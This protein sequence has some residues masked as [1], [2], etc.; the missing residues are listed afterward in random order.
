MKREREEMDLLP[1]APALGGLGLVDPDPAT[2]G[3]LTGMNITLHFIC[4][5]VALRMV[6]VPPEVLNKPKHPDDS[7]PEIR[8]LNA[9]DDDDLVTVADMLAKHKAAG[10]NET[11]GRLDLEFSPHDE[12]GETALLAA[13]NKKSAYNTAIARLLVGAGSN[14]NAAKRTGWTP[15]LVAADNGDIE[16]VK[17]LASLGADIT[18]AIRNSFSLLH[19][20]ARAKGDNVAYVKYLVEETPLRKFL[21]IM[22]EDTMTP[23]ANAAETGNLNICKYLRPLSAVSAFDR[24]DDGSSPPR[25]NED[26]DEDEEDEGQVDYVYGCDGY[27]RTPLHCAAERGHKMVVDYLLETTH[28]WGLVRGELEVLVIDDNYQTPLHF[29]VIGGHTSIVRDLIG[30]DSDPNR[31]D[32]MGKTPLHYAALHATKS[33]ELVT[34]LFSRIH[35]DEFG[36][37]WPIDA[38]V[39]T[40]FGEKTAADLASEWGNTRAAAIIAGYAQRR[41]RRS[42]WY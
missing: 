40:E 6:P 34:A 16:A 14:V 19:I 39:K 20:V 8:L 4:R 35:E 3:D 15:I 18:H 9:I 41:R 30:A 36:V 31:R 28:E 7:R 21:T 32:M 10:G 17:W 42:S 5:R 37:V 11:A 27:I 2:L 24:R 1:C 29:A 38:N 23:L 25:L 13:L 33:V 22:D 12:E 26:E